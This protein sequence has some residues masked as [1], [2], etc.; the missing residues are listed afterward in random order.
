[1]YAR[2]ASECNS[3]PFSPVTPPLQRHSTVVVVRSHETLR[4]VRARMAAA[5]NLPVAQ[6]LIGLSQGS[7]ETFN[8]PN[9]ITSDVWDNPALS[10]TLKCVWGFGSARR[11]SIR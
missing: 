6:V 10:L 4:E 2:A 8:K 11:Q 5:L 1:M 3:N 9:S 7:L